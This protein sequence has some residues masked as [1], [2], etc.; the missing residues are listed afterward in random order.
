M[1]LVE[2]LFEQQT[3]TP[4]QVPPVQIVQHV[5][6][7]ETKQPEPTSQ[8]DQDV[9]QE[10]PEQQLSGDE[11][12]AVQAQEMGIAPDLMPIKKYYLINR[13]KELKTQLGEYSIQNDELNIVLKFA[14][15]L[16][17]SSLLSIGMI[18]IDFIEQQLARLTDGKNKS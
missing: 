8:Q 17:Y 7:P 16:S 10:Q 3:Q 1:F 13:L 9:P 5:N 11:L 18:L 4:S 14:D 12:D 6:Q 2:V 15:N